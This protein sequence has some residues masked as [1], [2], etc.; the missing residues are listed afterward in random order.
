MGKIIILQLNKVKHLQQCPVTES[1]TFW[2]SIYILNILDP[3][4]FTINVGIINL[5]Y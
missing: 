2:C 1:V 5:A 4:I 3:V